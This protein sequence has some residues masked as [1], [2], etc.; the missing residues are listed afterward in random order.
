[1]RNE[2]KL[3]SSRLKGFA[4][5]GGTPVGSAVSDVTGLSTPRRPPH[6]KVISAR[7]RARTL[8]DVLVLLLKGSQREEVVGRAGQRLGRQEAVAAL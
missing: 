6:S 8:S 2:N 7:A 1:M 4:D 3:S 5:F